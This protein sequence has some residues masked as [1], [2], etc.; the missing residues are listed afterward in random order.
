MSRDCQ[1][2]LLLCQIGDWY[3]KQLIPLMEGAKNPWP[4]EAEE[5]LLR[6]YTSEEILEVIRADL[7]E[8]RIDPEDSSTYE[9]NLSKLHVKT[10]RWYSIGFSDNVYF[11]VARGQLWKINRVSI[12]LDGEPVRSTNLSFVYRIGSDG[13][14]RAERYDVRCRP[15]DGMELE[16]LREFVRLYDDLATRSK[17]HEKCGEDLTSLL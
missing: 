3:R 12:N 11:T 13:R 9:D 1:I 17:Y 15:L 2:D 6:R 16:V 8:G 10:T 14:E 7:E 5:A 4:K